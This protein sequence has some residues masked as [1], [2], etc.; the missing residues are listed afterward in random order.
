MADDFEKQVQMMLF[1]NSTASGDCR[2]RLAKKIADLRHQM[3]APMPLMDADRFKHL[4]G[5][6]FT[7]AVDHAERYNEGVFVEGDP[8][9]FFRMCGEFRALEAAVEYFDECDFKYSA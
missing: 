1:D 7:A 8:E 5:K 6:L 9:Y 4:S 3:D 2:A